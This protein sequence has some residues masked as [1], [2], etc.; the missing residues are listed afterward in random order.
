MKLVRGEDVT[1]EVDVTEK[2][3]DMAGG[4]DGWGEDAASAAVGSADK[5]NRASISLLALVCGF[6]TPPEDTGRLIDGG[7]GG[8]ASGGGNFVGNGEDSIILDNALSCGSP[9]SSLSPGTKS[10]K[11]SRS[12]EDSAREC[13]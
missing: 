4:K 11:N 2:V 12:S 7:L 13:R 5:L 8:G 3:G 1:D 10:D 6:G 9:S